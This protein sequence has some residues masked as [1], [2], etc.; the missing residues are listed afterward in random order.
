AHLQHARL[1][2]G[3]G[4]YFAHARP[5]VLDPEDRGLAAQ[6]DDRQRRNRAG[7]ARDAQADEAADARLDAVVVVAQL[8]DHRHDAQVRK[9]LRMRQRSTS[10]RATSRSMRAMSWSL[11]ALARSR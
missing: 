3:T 9:G 4:G 6:L 8:D 2:Q 5:A 11:T 10:C 1:D 7:R